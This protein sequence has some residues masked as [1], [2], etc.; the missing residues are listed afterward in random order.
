MAQ[1]NDKSRQTIKQE[2][3]MKINYGE[4]REIRTARK[5]SDLTEIVLKNMQSI[6]I[7]NNNNQ[8]CLSLNVQDE[9]AEL[10]IER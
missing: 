1:M 7:R 3:I 6:Y 10:W 2:I 4:I 9:K 8:F 5:N